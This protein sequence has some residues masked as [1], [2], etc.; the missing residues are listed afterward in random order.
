MAS[1]KKQKCLRRTIKIFDTT[2]RDG[3]QG[4]HISLSTD[5]K[6][7]IAKRLDD[8]GI[9]YIEGGWPGSNPKDFQFFRKMKNVQLR[10]SKL[11]AFGSTRR[12][13]LNPNNDSNLNCLLE[14]ETPVIS[15]FGKSWILHVQNALRITLKENLSMIEDSVRFLKKHGKEIIYDAEH[16][17]DGYRD[18]PKYAMKTLQVAQQA[19][20]DVVVLC[21]TNGGMLPDELREIVRKVKSTLD[22]PI[23][24]HT[25]NDSGLAVANTIMAVEEGCSH[26]QGTINGWGERCGN[27]N[28]C[29]VIPNLQLKS[30][31][32]CLHESKIARL[33]EL[34]HFVCEIANVPHPDNMPFVGKS[35]FAHKGGIHVSAV[36]RDNRTYEHINPSL[37]G[38]R[39]R[40]LVSDLSGRSNVIFKARELGID[41]DRHKEKVEEILKKLKFM[42][43]EGYQFEAAEGSFELLIRKAVGEWK[44]YFTLEGFRVLVEKDETGLPRSEASIR[45][46]VDG[47]V[48]HTAAEGNGPVNALDRALRKALIKFFPQIKDMHLSDYK[49]RDLNTQ[50][51][52]CARVRVLIESSNADFRWCTIGVS[53]NILEASWQALADSFNY[54]LMKIK[55]VK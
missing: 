53:E 45:V 10:N 25:H 32:A 33:T 36:M 2:L 55:M 26:V 47:E 28:L 31:Y 54:F 16:F 21:D 44:D 24:I 19:G 13:G 1:E 8:F 48:E 52:T 41:L 42:E 5:D 18:D 43:N 37:I 9:H 3:T 22:I 6:I 38:N 34:S 14:A 12:A 40:V 20:A 29:T 49:V 30:G 51:G 7:R 50:N 27:A 35:A 17:F 46:N 39:Q 4:E 23:G 11:V 15:L